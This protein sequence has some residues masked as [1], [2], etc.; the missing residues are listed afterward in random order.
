MVVTALRREP[1]TVF[2]ITEAVAYDQALERRLDA[3]ADTA[4]AEVLA[5]VD[6]GAAVLE[7]AR[8]LARAGAELALERGVDCPEG[9]RLRAAETLARLVAEIVLRAEGEALVEEA[10]RRLG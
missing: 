10:G 8:R 4:A 9:A 2:S 7:L 6:D 5:T 3:M 1:T